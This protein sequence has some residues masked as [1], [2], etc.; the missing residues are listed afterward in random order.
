MDR[1][2]HTSDIRVFLTLVLG[3]VLGF[4]I[5]G[6]ASTIQQETI[7]AIHF[8]DT[9]QYIDTEDNVAMPAFDQATQITLPHD[10]RATATHSSWYQIKFS[11]TNTGQPMAAY[12]PLVNMNAALYLNGHF[13]SST[14][15]FSEPMSRFW[16]T[17]VIFPLPDSQ[18][19]S[20]ENTLQIRLKASPPNDLTQLGRVF[21]GEEDIARQMYA[22][23][24]F[25]NHTLHLMAMSTSF[26][27]GFI[28]L[29]LWFL[30]R[31][32]EY[33]FFS[34]ACLSWGTTALNVVI[35]EPPIPTLFWEWLMNSSV[36]LAGIFIAMFLRRMMKIPYSLADHLII[37]SSIFFC[38]ILLLVPQSWFFIVAHIW[39]AIAIGFGVYAVVLLVRGLRQLHGLHSSILASGFFIVAGFAIHDLFTQIGVL[40]SSER[41]WLDYSV[42]VLMLAIAIVLIRR[43]VEAS[44]GLEEVN[45]TLEQRIAEAE[46][47]IEQDYQTIIQLRTQA[48]IHDERQRI[49]GD[50][51]DELGAKLLSLVYKSESD[52]QRQLARQAM[53]GLREIVSCNQQELDIDWLAK[54]R[55][56]SLQRFANTG[57]TL[58]WQQSQKR[59]A[60]GSDA[61]RMLQLSSIMREAL[62]NAIKHGDGQTVH[63][64]VW[65]R[66]DHL[67]MSV[68]NR[69]SDVEALTATGNGKRH[70]QRR[71][72]S[73][74]G[75][76]RW[77]FN[78]VSDGNNGG[79]HVLWHV[80]WEGKH[81]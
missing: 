49:Y 31:Q 18:L 19:N 11:A 74:G 53:N 24:Y 50:L 76:I 2:K 15:H 54:L 41:F 35:H 65:Q 13:L 26:F 48:A 45:A 4:A 63:I 62:T 23:D 43:F 3:L 17:P 6:Y 81:E 56:E 68:R 52:E 77:R 10:S 25:F 72:E 70:M 8:I 38:C 27:L 51:H 58:T 16:H 60:Q 20:G 44:R 7:P 34:L 21:T 33:L 67:W 47:R 42:P 1:G 71:I 64:R 73:L 78:P 69:G 5:S 36:S 66:C 12:L 37:G 79:C 30:R 75:R 80:P 57:M 29:Y 40:P 32:D 14:G 59:W 39:H 9:A 55:Q 28:V 61:N 46:A 22:K